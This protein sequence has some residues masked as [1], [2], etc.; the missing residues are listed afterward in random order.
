MRDDRKK[1][2]L[3]SRR[4]GNPAGAAYACL[5]ST[6]MFLSLAVNAFLALLFVEMIARSDIIAA[7]EWI[8]W[9]KDLAFVCTTLILV[10]SGALLMCTGSMSA[11]L[12]GVSRIRVAKRIALFAEIRS[13][14]MTV[15]LTSGE[16]D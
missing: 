4:K 11:A 9:R 8:A 3:P 5:R 7:L 13:Y 10:V 12:E 16:G 2:S 14:A 1:P 15:D 6:G